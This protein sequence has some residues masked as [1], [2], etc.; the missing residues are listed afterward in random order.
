MFRKLGQRDPRPGRVPTGYIDF[1][2]GQSVWRP[3]EDKITLTPIGTV[4]RD[5]ASILA[6][7]SLQEA[8]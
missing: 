1:V 4:A 2:C 7:N 5:V 8:S 6:E 3:L